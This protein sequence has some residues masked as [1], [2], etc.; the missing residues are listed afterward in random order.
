MGLKILHS[1][2]WHLDSPFAS[3]DGEPRAFLQQAQRRIPERLRALCAEEH[4]DLVLL[5]GDIFDGP[6]SRET[7][8]LLADALE[9]CGVP[10]FIS[11]GNHDFYGPESPWVRENWPA[12]VHIFSGRLS[13]VDLPELD[14]RIYGAGYGAMDCPGVLEGFRAEREFGHTVAVLHG[15]PT[16]GRS[17]YCPITASQVRDSG[18]DY[19]ALG[20]I[21]QSGSFRAGDT[22]CGWPGCP[23]GRGWDETGDKGILIVNLDQTPSALPAVLPLPKFHDLRVRVNRDAPAALDA[24]LPPAESAD[25]FRVTLEGS[26][27][28]DLGALKAR[29]SHLGYLELR[30]EREEERDPFDLSDQD[31]L[32]GVFFR[33]L[34]EQLEGADPEQAEIIRLAAELSARLLDGKEVTLP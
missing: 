8:A 1:A 17:P 19:L 24:V 21:H 27:T 10:V 16:G 28:T 25:L 22:L 34:E 9:D 33:L 26:G 6:Y 32:R 7:A 2:D 4:C 15:D 13:Y 14:C 23:M 30:D 3:F 20:H 29:Y 31:S 12:N 5:A 18:L 11:P